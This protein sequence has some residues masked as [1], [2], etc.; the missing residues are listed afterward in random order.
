MERQWVWGSTSLLPLSKGELDKWSSMWALYPWTVWTQDCAG[1]NCK[2]ARIYRI[3]VLATRSLN[4]IKTKTFKILLPQSQTFL[5][6][7]GVYCRSTR[8]TR[9]WTCR[10]NYLRWRKKSRANRTGLN[11]RKATKMWT[12]ACQIPQSAP[13]AIRL[14]WKE[15]Q[16]T[17][18]HQITRSRLILMLSNQIHPYWAPKAAKAKSP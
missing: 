6:H 18:T 10:P 4:P 16:T 17:L 5:T 15:Q 3:Q 7:A 8:A 13:R 9:T 1:W 12:K 14:L 2:T 11:R